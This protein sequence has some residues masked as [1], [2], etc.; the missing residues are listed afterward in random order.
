MD[1]RLGCALAILTSVLIP[2]QAAAQKLAFVSDRDGNSEIYVADVRDNSATNITGHLGS[3]T[4]PSW[5]PDGT[6]ILFKSDRTGESQSYVMNWDGSGQTSLALDGDDCGTQWSNDGTKILLSRWSNHRGKAYVAKPDGSGL[7]EVANVEGC[8]EWSPDGTKILYMSDPYLGDLFV[9][10][11]DSQTL[12]AN[13]PGLGDF[14]FHGRQWSPDSSRILVP[15][16][17]G[18]GIVNG[19]KFL[20]FDF[21]SRHLSVISAGGAYSIHDGN[22]PWALDAEGRWSP[23]SNKILVRSLGRFP[24]SGTGYVYV[25]NADGSGPVDISASP[26]GLQ[27]EDF[28]TTIWSPDSSKLLFTSSRSGNREI[29]VAG[30]DGSSPI[31]LSNSPANDVDPVWSPDGSRIFFSSDG[32]DSYAWYSVNA[33]GSGLEDLSARFG[34]GY[35]IQPFGDFSSN[36][37]PA[38]STGGIVLANLVPAVNTVSPLALVSIFGTDFSA[39]SV[40]YPNLDANGTIDTILGE[41]CVEIGGQ[42]APIFAITPNQAN[43]QMPGAP[44]FGP[45]SVTVIRNCGKADEVRSQTATVTVEEAT[46]AFFL[47]PPYKADGLIAARFNDGYAAVAPQAIIS[48]GQ[49]PSRPA[50]R[51]DIILLFGTGWGAT[52]PGFATGQLAAGA[53]A[54]LPSA[55]PMVTFGGIPLAAE[56]VLYV[57]ATPDAAGLYQLAIRVPATAMPGANQ[58]VLTVYGKSTPD[59][60]VVTVAGP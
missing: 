15:S 7:T 18:P 37:T 31:N 35:D 60:P 21:A 32:A 6:K 13:S 11:V 45:V 20:V 40:F 16:D 12:L 43:V 46:P 1:A 26:A 14:A 2:V 27:V 4:D 24:D 39:G 48:D 30:A 33:D 59:G 22:V 56:N 17:S 9:L 5:S 57:G 25:M 36:P 34:R 38:I 55:N 29:Y 49:G 44:T 28:D 58:V 54:L 51:G 50:N 53:P 19:V 41:T 8:P 23:D 52:T 10:D 47:Y 3:D 42:R